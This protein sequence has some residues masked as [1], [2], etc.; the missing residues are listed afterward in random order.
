M[1]TLLHKLFGSSV[2]E[3]SDQLQGLPCPVSIHSLKEHHR[4][5][6]IGWLANRM[7]QLLHVASCE[8][9]MLIYVSFS[10]ECIE[11]NNGS[12]EDCLI[13]L[14][15]CLFEW[16]EK[17][18]DVYLHI[19]EIQLLDKH[20]K[21][22]LDVYE[23]IKE[24]IYHCFPQKQVETAEGN[25]DDEVWQV[26]RDVIHAAT[27]KKFLLIRESGISLYK[28]GKVLCEATIK[29]R[30]DI[31]K[32]RDLAKQKLHSIGI[33]PSKIMSHL[34][35]ISEAITNILK[36]AIEGK[37]TIVET[38]SS[39][40]VLVEDKGPGFQLKILPYTT[41]MAGYSTKKS[42]G[43]GFTLMMKM[44]DQ[45]LLSTSSKGST[46]ILVFNEKVGAKHEV[47]V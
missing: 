4:R 24:D 46:I 20:H 17:G 14:A 29:E 25:P 12:E 19:K 33:P 15:S 28:Q 32:A 31:P 34:L 36:H 35:I 45:V 44:A 21:C 9:G 3:S 41:L 5:A 39:L 40:H 47:V 16:L 38:D 22:L 42:L 7:G 1:K 27:Q 11:Q 10:K 37:L 30:S 8:S 18:Q 23:E 2:H 6:L 13:Y 43:Q 26:Y